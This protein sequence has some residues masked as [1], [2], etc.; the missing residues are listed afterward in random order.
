MVVLM[1]VLL[2]LFGSKDAPKIFRKLNDIMS[3][4]RSAAENFKREV[5]YSDME[6]GPAPYDE[7]GEYDDYGIN[8]QPDTHDGEMEE[9]GMKPEK[10]G[11]SAQA[12]D[13]GGDVPKA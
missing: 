9:P 11:D 2:L 8:T 12:E 4:I 3:Q 10:S 6:A 13:E 1:L 5:M 7:V